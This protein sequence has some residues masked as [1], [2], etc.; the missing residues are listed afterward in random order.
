MGLTLRLALA[1]LRHRPVLALC[2]ALG[3]AAVLAPLILLAGLR[4][5]VIGGLRAALLEDPRATEIVTIANRDIPE[6]TLAALAA[7]GDVAFLVPRTRALSAAIQIEEPGGRFGRVELLPSAP[8]DPL[9]AGQGPARAGEVIVSAS[10]ARRL[11]LAPGATLFGVV[12]RVSGGERQVLRLPLTVAA[13]APPAAAPRDSLFAAVPLLVTVEDFLDGAL[14]EDAAPGDSAG[15]RA[16]AG[17]RLHAAGIEAVPALAADLAAQGLPVASRAEEVGALLRLDRDLALLFAILA[18]MG[19]A[20]YVVSLA[21]GMW[22]QVERQRRDLALLALFG[23]PRAARRAVPV[24]Q[25]AAIG[26]GGAALG[27]ALALA[28]EAALNAAFAGGVTGERPV[29][30]IT[31]AILGLAIV[32][33]CAGAMLSA[34]AG[35]LR[36]SAIEPAEGLVQE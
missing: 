28:A 27:G 30:V 20:G 4:E 29:S 3:L 19:G 8:G 31:P 1:D 24:V 5:G 13:V 16:F 18:G 17:F 22:A 9:L 34:A 2:A 26:A 10:L 7:R 32:A 33:T 36:A 11:S 35:A 6:A 14:G 21:V 15:P 25:A 12:G 23:L